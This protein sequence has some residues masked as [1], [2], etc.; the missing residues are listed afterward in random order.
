MNNHKIVMN[1]FLIFFSTL[2]VVGCG[3]RRVP[4]EDV[5]MHHSEYKGSD[6]ANDI[7]VETIKDGNLAGTAMGDH[8]HVPAI[9]PLSPT[10]NLQSPKYF[11][12]ALGSRNIKIVINKEVGYTEIAG[13]RF[14][15]EA[16]INIGNDGTVEVN[17]EGVEASDKTGTFW[18][19]KNV[20]I[21]GSDSLTTVMIRKK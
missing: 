13:L 18:I 1:T 21:E 19:S 5:Y 9:I 4:R 20:K 3:Q 6:G 11:P 14:V 15:G 7:Q 10:G 16:V 2:L 12:D 8:S 17:K